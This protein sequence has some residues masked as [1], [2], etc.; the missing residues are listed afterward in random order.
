MN[1]AQLNFFNWFRTTSLKDQYKCDNYGVLLDPSQAEADYMFAYWLK[2]FG[3]SRGEHMKGLA[4]I[5][6]PFLV[7]S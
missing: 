7:K 4:V 1:A 6:L 3:F 5:S 2:Q